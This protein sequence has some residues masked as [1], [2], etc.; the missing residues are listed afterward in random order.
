MNM[1]ENIFK[2]IENN[3]TD[4]KGI[5]FWSWNDK[6]QR[7]EL[8][9]Q[10]EAMNKSS[11]GGFFMHARGGLVTSYLSDE[12]FSYVDNCIKEAKK[13]GMKAW[14]YDENGWP[15]GFAAGA[16]PKMG[17]EYQQKGLE[18]FKLS[19]DDHD[20]AD[21]LAA[22]SVTGEN[23]CKVEKPQIGD[24]AIRVKINPY[25]I[26]ALNRNSI[27][28]FIEVTHQKY[29]ERFSKDFGKTM[30]G[31]F[32]DE[33]QYAN[34]GVVWSHV[35]PELF[36]NKY[37]YSLKDNLILLYMDI[38]GYRSFRYDYYNLASEL[39]VNG[40]IK[41]LYDW[42]ED[43]NC[44][45]TGHVVA[46]D[47][48]TYQ[49]ACTGGA[50]PCYEFF[51][52]PG[53]D[54]LGREI[55]NPVVPKQVASVARQ[56]GKSFAI[57]ESFALS[58]WD[59]SFNELK[60]IAEWQFL[61]GINIICGHLE[62]YSLRGFRKRD[63]PP[64]L[65]VQQP[66]FS[67]YSHFNDY[68]SRLGVLLSQGIDDTSVLVLHSL[69][70]AYM[71]FNFNNLK[72][73]KEYSNEFIKTTESLSG[74]HIEHHYGDEELIRKYGKV[75]DGLFHIGFCSYSKIVLPGMQTLDN[76]TFELLLEFKKQGGEI[77]S[78]GEVPS[79]IAG[80]D[81]LAIGELTSQIEP[82]GGERKLPSLIEPLSEEQQIIKNLMTGNR[83]DI[84]EN[85]VQC[86]KIQYCMR[87]L[88]DN[89][90]IY[91]VVN[92]S[93]ENQKANLRFNGSQSI[94][95]LDIINETKGTISSV[96]VDNTTTLFLNFEASQSYILLVKN[97]EG[98]TEYLTD[99]RE[100]IRLEP[101]FSIEKQDLN[102]IT[103]DKCEYRIDDDDWQKEKA[104]ILIQ[105]ELL[106]L[107]KPCEIAMRFKFDIEDILQM[108]ELYLA[109][110]CPEQQTIFINSVQ[111]DNNDVC[112]FFV[113]KSFN[114]LNMYPFL[115]SGR[116]EMIIRR[117]FYQKQK[118]YEVLFGNVHESEMNMLTYDVELESCYLVGD[119]AVNNR[120]ESKMGNRKAILT[121][122]E[123]VL[124][125]KNEKINIS[126]ITRQGFWFFSGSL[127][128]SQSF[129]LSKKENIRYILKF[130]RL[131]TPLAKIMVNGYDAGIIAF[132]P[133]ELDV[134]D[135]VENGTNK[136]CI[137]LF[138][139]NRN[140]L[141][142]HHYA[143]GESY[144]VGPNTFTDKHGWSDDPSVPMWNDGYCFIDFGVEI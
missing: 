138:S 124:T 80:R 10:I 100:F 70:T 19:G 86:K 9:E 45:L 54:W 25:Y 102:S 136:I 75:S 93:K 115:K 26:D 129:K 139:S 85:G 6:L 96:V 2:N 30:Q 105:E 84:S 121:N 69:K 64:S 15:S 28:R 7:E 22:F 50:M 62:S 98:T 110:E 20:L 120:A 143:G 88:E 112:G 8:T 63:Y 34:G 144:S 133:F 21:V 48:L 36:E 24:Y 60:H 76:Q 13:H 130:K 37:G 47:D 103:L 3:K 11:M 32:T 49:V 79:L 128:L 142:P 90:R 127:T 94:E 117:A 17:V 122:G 68:M 118:V 51:H 52:M 40:F 44:K 87:I 65:F 12:W 123:F 95:L 111:I 101:E 55:G 106:S 56:L 33:P 114:K 109:I 16:V 108:N 104:I 38:G 119:F 72:T 107:K 91:F 58:G 1:A 140:L 77:F 71:H 82:L 39:F 113:D 74:L 27:T 14:C 125:R 73:V 81:N 42:C 29:Y 78:M 5:P 132:A 31:F 23:F 126:N 135:F 43:H 141:G 89:S 18:I 4:Y 61:N 131:N 59:V 66:W 137:E 46:E 83:L 134:T 53:M 67:E 116:N 57:T 92:L 99:T 35:L 97:T 41:Q